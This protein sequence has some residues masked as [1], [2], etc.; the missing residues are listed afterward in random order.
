MIRKIK[1]TNLFVILIISFMSILLLFN[2]TNRY[3][4]ADESV[5]SLMGRNIL[6]YGF[7]K[8]WDGTNLAMAGVNGNEFNED[9]IHIRNNWLSFYIA[10]FGQWISTSLNLNEQASVGMMRCLFS[11]I[12]ILGAIAYYYLVNELCNGNRIISIFSLCLFAFSIPVLLYIRSVYY[13]APTLTF[14][15]TSVLFYLRY[16]STQTKKYLIF[17]TISCILLFHSFYPYFFIVMVSLML[18]YF[19]FDF[20]AKSF[21]GLLISSLF[22]LALTTPWFVYIRLFLS[23]VEKNGI[24][25]LEFFYKSMLGYIWQIHAYFFPFIPILILV[26][27]FAITRR[28][29]KK[30]NSLNTRTIKVLWKE[31]RKYRT[32]FLIS[33]IILIN[34]FIISITNNFLDTR[35]LI[36]S[37]PFLLMVFAF[38]LYYIYKNVKLI[39]ASLL[40]LSIFTNMLHISPYLVMRNYD[41]SKVENFVAPPL[42]YFNSDPT[43]QNK[44]ADLST[45]L[46]DLCKIESYP[47]NYVEEIFNTYNDADK[48]MILFLTK[49][50]EKGQKV[51]LVGYQY[52]TI[53]YYTG[54]QV[55]NRLDP[56]SDPLPSIYK[57]YPN[58]IRY[59]HLTQYPIEQCDWII[60]RYPASLGIQDALW[61][62]ESKFEKIY[63]DYPD[64]K[65]W[66]EIWDHSFYTD[67][68]YPGIYIYRNRLTT[69]PIA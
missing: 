57:A 66:N 58:A 56:N 6:K 54:L 67:K 38:C 28:V 4:F 32:G 59:Q 15:I 20:Q 19:I 48:G 53:A 7:P 39:G 9:L 35:R 30:R 5:E 18:V 44:K 29:R 69:K 11:L 68:S 21:R 14:T 10:A 49:Y 42:P 61:H 62:E 34:L 22:I 65:P 17:F 2:L 3:M 52:E 64:S 47:L 60:E 46:Q 43:W 36:S 25:T 37:I 26:I 1:S 63:I 13:L 8:V 23:K 40:F 55:V 50:A 16:I 12:G 41:V 33:S 24:T 51:Y 45:Y 27:I 31:R